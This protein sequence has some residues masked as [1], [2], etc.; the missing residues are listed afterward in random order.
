MIAIYHVLT[1]ALHCCSRTEGPAAARSAAPASD[2]LQHS[3]PRP[4]LV[5]ISPWSRGTVRRALGGHQTS[6]ETPAASGRRQGPAGRPA[7]LRPAVML[8]NRDGELHS[9]APVTAGSGPRRRHRRGLLRSLPGSV[10]AGQVLVG[11]ARGPDTPLVP[12]TPQLTASAFLVRFSEIGGRTVQ[13]VEPRPDQDRRQEQQ[14]PDQDRRHEQQRPDQDRRQFHEQSQGQYGRPDSARAPAQKSSRPSGVSEHPRNQYQTESA[15]NTETAT[16]LQSHRPAGVSDSH[17][18]LPDGVVTSGD[19]SS[20]R[21][22][23]GHPA[24]S[25]RPD[26]GHPAV[27]LRPDPGHPAV[28]L[29]PDPGH[30]AVSLRPDPGHPAVSLRPDPGHPAAILRPDPG[31]PAVSL[32]PDPGHPAAILRPDPGHPAVSL[33]PDPGHPAVSLRPDPGHP[34]VSLRPDPGH[35]AVS[36]HPDPGH[37]AVSPHHDQS[38]IQPAASSVTVTV[39]PAQPDRHPDRHPEYQAET[40]E[41]AGRYDLRATDHH[42]DHQTS[43]R[44]QKYDAVAL[45]EQGGY[46]R[47]PDQTQEY[48]YHAQDQSH[49]Y[50]YDVPDQDQGYNYDSPDQFQV[51]ITDLQTTHN[52][53]PSESSVFPAQHTQATDS[54]VSGPDVSSNSISSVGPRVHPLSASDSSRPALSSSVPRNN[55]SSSVSIEPT[56]GGNIRAGQD[57]DQ[58]AGGGGGGGDGPAFSGGRRQASDPAR[59]PHVEVSGV[60]RHRSSAQTHSGGVWRSEATSEHHPVNVNTDIRVV[61]SVAP[62]EPEQVATGA[63]IGQSASETTYQYNP[64]SSGGTRYR[65]APPLNEYQYKLAATSGAE[66]PY[67]T[68]SADPGHQNTPS[69]TVTGF[70]NNPPSASDAGYRHNS[71]SAAG[72]GRQYGTTVSGGTG[73]HPPLTGESSTNTVTV[74]EFHEDHWH[75]PPSGSP[76]STPPSLSDQWRP[77]T[78]QTALTP[79]VVPPVP[80]A[81]PGPSTARPSSGDTGPSQ[82]QLPSPPALS[83]SPADPEFPAPGL[84]AAAASPRGLMWPVLDVLERTMVARMVSAATAGEPD[85]VVVRHRGSDRPPRQ[86]PRRRRRRAVGVEED[87]TVTL[88]APVIEA[89]PTHGPGTAWYV[90]AAQSAAPLSQLPLQPPAAVWPPLSAAGRSAAVSTA[91]RQ[92]ADSGVLPA[93]RS[94]SYPEPWPRRLQPGVALELDHSE[95]GTAAWASVPANQTTSLLDKFPFEPSSKILDQSGKLGPDDID[96]AFGDGFFTSFSDKHFPLEDVVIPD[97][98]FVDEFNTKENSIDTDDTIE[99]KSSKPSA[100]VVL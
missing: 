77:M 81:A 45:D 57:G 27:S 71:A 41:H 24:V 74:S 66:Y 98:Y 29:R 44:D 18:I 28:S 46:D 100:L 67:T 42:R 88:P 89:A 17:I 69:A 85:G 10:G 86:Q 20:L 21:P 58:S 84:A 78:H 39:R 15:D 76:G 4:T 53:K 14:R 51:P 26:P 36:L 95:N 12:V 16:G 35:P 96:S 50:N 9:L 61:L 49:E 99:T 87:Y 5:S 47:V 19:F 90:T 59:R 83:P 7:P 64:S 34:A 23:L 73:Y 30:P 60:S 52:T 72:E 13:V 75:R 80:A 25:L 68:A 92:Q 63:K 54:A 32:R 43:E 56:L 6:P 93:P 38:Q 2:R 62:S 70:Q 33:R 3:P 1:A 8:V 22:D 31:H 65:Y 97:F 48:G 82:H 11:L 37:P 40:R 94:V 55:P 91:D 79:S